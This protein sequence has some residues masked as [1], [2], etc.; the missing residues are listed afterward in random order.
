M[1]AFTASDYFAFIGFVTGLA[2]FVITLLRFNSQK[3]I[4]KFTVQSC[5]YD[6]GGLVLNVI[7]DNSGERGTTIT[8]IELDYPHPRFG[9]D[10]PENEFAWSMGYWKT[11]EEF[12]KTFLIYIP[13]TSSIAITAEFSLEKPTLYGMTA[14][15]NILMT[16]A[17]SKLTTPAQYQDEVTRNYAIF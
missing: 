14:N 7:I 9:P 8:S 3:P 15:F 10:D 11:A 5:N 2:S 16:H 6:P 17:A 12:I 13:P 1:S 4:L